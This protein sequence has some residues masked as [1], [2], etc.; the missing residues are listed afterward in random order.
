MK[1]P[2]TVLKFVL[3]LFLL[4]IFSF[5]SLCSDVGENY[6]GLKARCATEQLLVGLNFR[7]FVKRG[8]NTPD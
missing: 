6:F 3:C 1:A 4:F 8:Y 2:R 5:F 7:D